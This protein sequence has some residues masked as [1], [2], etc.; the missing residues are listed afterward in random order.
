MLKIMNT[1]T[2]KKTSQQSQ[3]ADEKKKV[4]DKLVKKAIKTKANLKTCF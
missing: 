2:K 1:K 3:S 4:I